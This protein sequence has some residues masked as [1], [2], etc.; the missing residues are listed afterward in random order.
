MWNSCGG[1]AVLWGLGCGVV[2]VGGRPEVGVEAS[3][4]S[5]GEDL[6]GAVDR[7]YERWELG[8][9]SEMGLE[10]LQ[11]EPRMAAT[12]A[13]P[14]LVTPEGLGYR[15]Q[16]VK[17]EA[18]GDDGPVCMAGS[19]FQEVCGHGNWRW[20]WKPCDKWTCDICREHKLFGELVPEILKALAEARRQ[21][22][23][24][25]LLT[26]TWQA[27]TLGAQPTS[28]GAER[29]RLDEQHLIQWFKRHGYLPKKGEVFYLRVAETHRSGKVHLHLYLVTPFVDHAELKAAWRTITGGSYIIDLQTV[30]LKCPNCWVRGQTRAEKHR[31]SITPWPG[32]G[33]CSDCGYSIADPKRLARSIAV[34]AGKYLAKDG[35][36]GVKKKLTRSGSVKRYCSRCNA[37][38]RQAD[39]E[40]GM[41]L[42]Q[43]CERFDADPVVHATG[44]ARFRYEVE[45]ERAEQR[46]K[47]F[48]DDCEDEHGYTYVGTQLE[49][50]VQY[51][52]FEAVLA[53]NGGRGMGFASVNGAPCLCWGENVVWESSRFM[54]DHGLGDLA[55]KVRDG[56]GDEDR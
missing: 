16:D 18:S 50:L 36:E 25:K 40:S 11:S 32:S 17:A 10:D 23:T 55:S 12:A 7:L 30:Y 51:S 1:W 3:W 37:L 43:V 48:C 14:S 9:Q 45:Q 54:A 38:M 2:A 26:L 42:C 29:R 44:W 19:V 21:R 33:K 56:P 31:R 13:M 24:L 28:E 52:G 6:G 15:T 47:G 8:L 27:Q 41:Y 34:E 35:T 5:L 22:V 53:F 4:E 49:L 39:M 20:I 46:G